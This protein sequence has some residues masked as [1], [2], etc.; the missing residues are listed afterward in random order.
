MPIGKF[1][2]DCVSAVKTSGPTQPT[3]FFLAWCNF[4]RP[5]MVLNTN[6]CVC[7]GTCER[8]LDD[9]EPLL[10]KS[11]VTLTRDVRP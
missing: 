6:A 4:Y 11:T 7:G 10:S 2:S 1:R 5:H 3:R 8:S 9:M